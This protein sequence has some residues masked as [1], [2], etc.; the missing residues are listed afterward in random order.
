MKRCP[1]CDTGSDETADKC[2]FCGYRF[3]AVNISSESSVTEIMDLISEIEQSISGEEGAGLDEDSPTEPVRRRRADEEDEFT[4][5]VQEELQVASDEGATPPVE[6]GTPLTSGEASM[7]GFPDDVESILRGLE[8]EVTSSEGKEE[9]VEA[10]RGVQPPDTG[11][12]VAERRAPAPDMEAARREINALRRRWQGLS[13]ALSKT[14]VDVSEAAGVM[15]SAEERLIDGDVETASRRYRE[16]IAMLIKEFQRRVT[17]EYQVLSRQNRQVGDA[18][19]RQMLAETR[20]RYG[21]GDVAGTLRLL[22]ETRKA[23]GRISVAD[24]ATLGE[25]VRSLIPILGSFDVDLTTVQ[26][27]V[28]NADALIGRGRREDA[29]PTLV[30]AYNSLVRLLAR[31][32]AE[33][34]ETAREA[35]E[36]ARRRRIRISDQ[37]ALLKK[38]SIL[39]KSRR[40]VECA[41]CLEEFHRGIQPVLRRRRR[42]KRRRTVKE[43]EEALPQVETPETRGVPAPGPPQGRGDVPAPPEVRVPEVPLGGGYLVKER[44]PHIAYLL[45]SSMVGKGRPG[46]CICTVFPERLKE[47][48]D[49][50]GSGFIW[51]TTIRDA[52]QGYDPERLDF[53]VTQEIYE[54]ITSTREYIILFDALDML[55]ADQG[56]EKTVEF[57]RYLSDHAA[58]DRGI[59]LVAVSPLTVDKG[60]I[61]QLERFLEEVSLPVER[62]GLEKVLRETIR[63]TIEGRKGMGSSHLIDGGLSDISRWRDRLPDLSPGIVFSRERAE[64]VRSVIENYADW[65]EVYTISHI[66]GQSNV[67]VSDLRRFRKIITS[68]IGRSGRPLVCIEGVDMLISE[69]GLETVSNLLGDIRKDILYKSGMLLVILRSSSVDPETWAKIDRIM[70]QES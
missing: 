2:S 23:M 24:A 33:E 63:S 55:I 29:R 7:L 10:V 49:L 42:R 40:Y 19:V 52:D 12:P 64:R 69:H 56:N 38:A 9:D 45:Y 16:A 68:H 46:M 51:L 39:F 54:F 66:P 13:T 18:R 50:Y 53:E 62:D 67:P 28:A 22:A 4:R 41:R 43:Q 44:K 17:S 14:G 60:T 27:H 35:S 5:A 6:E 3:P 25:R 20:R 8:E 30:H 59:L 34:I 1:L 21:A 65:A 70:K 11:A 58:M 61:G 31:L 47:K 15:V 57:I 26:E 48:Y 36:I 37:L 32:L